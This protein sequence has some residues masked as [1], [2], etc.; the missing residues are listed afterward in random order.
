MIKIIIPTVLAHPKIKKCIDSVFEHTTG[1]YD[2]S[3]IRNEWKGFA[4]AVNIALR[5]F[6]KEKRLKAVVLLN[7]DCIVLKDW[8]NKIELK[9]KEDDKIGMI[10]ADFV[11]TNPP[12][13]PFWFVYIKREVVEKVGLLDERFKVGEYEDVDYCLRAVLTGWKIIQLKDIAEPI[14]CHSN[15][16]SQLSPEKEKLRKLNKQKF[17]EKWKNTPYGRLYK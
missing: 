11:R 4:W 2:L 3:V 12:H 7:D 8:R 5:Q 16:L 6:R 15:T 1:N 13:A 9:L 17:S 10:S 14:E